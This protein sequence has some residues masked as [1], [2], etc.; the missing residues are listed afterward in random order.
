VLDVFDGRAAWP[1]V[2]ESAMTEEDYDRLMRERPWPRGDIRERT[3][4]ALCSGAP[5][6][7]QNRH[8][9]LFPACPLVLLLM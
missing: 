1:R 5:T 2:E 7:F 9:F 3:V 8:D 4:S 6:Y